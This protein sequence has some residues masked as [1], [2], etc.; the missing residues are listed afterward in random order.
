[1]AVLGRR[2]ELSFQI[3]GPELTRSHGSNLRDVVD[4]HEIGVQVDY[5]VHL[6]WDHLRE[7]DPRVVERLI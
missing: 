4:D 3:D 5:A 7:I 2:Q 1:M 6:G